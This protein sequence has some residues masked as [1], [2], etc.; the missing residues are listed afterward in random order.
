VRLGR[1]PRLNGEQ[2]AEAVRLRAEG[3]SFADIARMLGVHRQT[4]RTALR[5]G[6]ESDAA[7]EA[8]PDVPDGGSEPAAVR[9]AAAVGVPDWPPPPD[10]ST[11]WIRVPLGLGRDAST[12]RVRRVR[13]G[14]RQLYVTVGGDVWCDDCCQV[15]SVD[16]CR[17]MERGSHRVSL[18]RTPFGVVRP[19]APGSVEPRTP[20]EIER[21][22]W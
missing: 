2:I 14:D 20:T 6:S 12:V 3:E 21:S 11:S 1:P 5:R 17:R 13:L 9:T 15:F 7:V 10:E 16:D 8:V 19:I 18:D 22:R 4:L